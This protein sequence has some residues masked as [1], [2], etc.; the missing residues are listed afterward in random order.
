[1][2]LMPLSTPGRIIPGGFRLEWRSCGPH[3]DPAQTQRAIGKHVYCFRSLPGRIDVWRSEM[4]DG[5][6]GYRWTLVHR[7]VKGGE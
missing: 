2:A 4:A 1:M 6:H 7:F 3:Y 5:A